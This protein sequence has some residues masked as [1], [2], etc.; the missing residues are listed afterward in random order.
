MDGERVLENKKTSTRIVR[1]CSRNIQRIDFISILEID[2][3]KVNNKVLCVE[4]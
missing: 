3:Y 1:T 2:R 4:T